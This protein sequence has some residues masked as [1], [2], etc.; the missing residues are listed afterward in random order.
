MPKKTS[1]IPLAGILILALLPAASSAQSGCHVDSSVQSLTPFPHITHLT[2]SRTGCFTANEVASTM[3]TEWAAF[4]R[5]P[6]KLS[7]PENDGYK[8]FVCK[9]RQY[10]SGQDGVYELASCSGSGHSVVT[11]HLGS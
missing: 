7:T 10:P 3:K 2:A 5:F 11:M 4:Q 1:A 9:Y 8:H 6:K